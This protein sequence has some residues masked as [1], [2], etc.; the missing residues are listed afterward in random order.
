MSKF[1]RR[2]RVYTAL[3]FMFEPL[4]TNGNC[5]VEEKLLITSIVRSIDEETW[6]LRPGRGGGV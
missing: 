6:E 1:G 3:V 4:I 5:D 2:F